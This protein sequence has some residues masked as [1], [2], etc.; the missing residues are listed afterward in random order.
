MTRG[1]RLFFWMYPPYLITALASMIAFTTFTARSASEYFFELSSI[2]L[3]ETTAVAANAVRP[4]VE[5]GASE[6]KIQELCSALV[7]GSRIR[8]TVI[9]TNGRVIADTD[10]VSDRMDFHLDREEVREAW[11]TGSGS[12]VRKSLSTGITTTYEAVMLRNKA[13]SDIGLLRAAMPFS[14]VGSRRGDLLQGMIVFGM[15]LFI[16]VSLMALFISRRIS[17]PILRIHAGARLFAEGRFDERIPEDGPLEIAHLASIM[18]RMADDLG[19][20]IRTVARQKNE[21]DSILNG[22]SEAVAVVDD[23]M[24]VLSWNPA[25][26]RLFPVDTVDEDASLARSARESLLSLTHNTDIC[27][28]MELALRADGPLETGISTYGDKP[29]QLRLT[30]SPLGEGKAVL[31][32]NDLTKMNRLETVRRDFTTNVSHELKTPITSIK[33]ALETLQ[34]AGFADQVQ[35]ASFLDMAVRGIQRL[36]AILADLF[37][38]ARI[39]EDEKRGIDT[40]RVEI[41][42]VIDSVL[43][44][45]APRLLEGS[46]RITREGEHGLA[47]LGN[48]GLLRQALLNLTD[49]AIKYA[50]SGGT[51]EL[52]TAEESGFARLSVRDHGPGIPARDRDRVF[53]RFY[54]IDRARSRESGGTGLGLSIVK[55]IAQVH[56]GSV[57]LESS[58]GTGSTFSILIPLAPRDA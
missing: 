40:Q 19:D 23:R 18:N 53:E 32:I 29:R 43:E 47:V 7:A 37:S 56:S 9:D 48:A 21:V 16:A 6:K 30:S 5:Q 24:T 52:V 44:D 34:D 12:A 38:L 57:Q 13:G 41:D 28:F 50:S 54:R 25:F 14:I 15:G 51:I 55:H 22:M 8:L 33:A 10:A 36:E 20:R 45:V 31:V 27:D 49:N 46:I 11:E 1:R 3:R 26:R 2:Q 39:E 42:A 17:R 58:E 35:A 4:L